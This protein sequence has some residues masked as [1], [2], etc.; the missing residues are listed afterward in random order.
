MASYVSTFIPSAKA[1]DV[2][3]NAP[4]ADFVAVSG[5][6]TGRAPD[7][8]SARALHSALV[9][10]VPDFDARLRDLAAFIK[11][12]AS[13][14]ASLQADLDSAAA[15]FAKL[16]AT[17]ATAWYVGTAG[18]GVPARCITYE[19]SLMFT[20]V[21]DRLKPPSYAYGPYGSWGRNPAAV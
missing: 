19:T 12:R 9:T 14:A 18:S 10:A 21:A 8:V 7:S 16:P 2:A 15:P 3:S 1:T 20:V 11:T 17:I 5:L 6:L 4:L 13:T